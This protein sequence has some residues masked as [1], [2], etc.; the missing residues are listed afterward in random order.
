M[1]SPDELAE[2]RAM[3]S[4]R[5]RYSPFGRDFG[6]GKVTWERP[7]VGQAMAPFGK[8]GPTSWIC[9]MVVGI[10][11]NPIPD[12]QPHLEPDGARAIPSTGSGWCLRH[13]NDE[14][15]FGMSMVIQ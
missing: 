1:A 3:C 2:W 6:I 14:R 8:V 15:L 4:T 13:V 9:R 11:R 10:C 12:K 7:S 5:M